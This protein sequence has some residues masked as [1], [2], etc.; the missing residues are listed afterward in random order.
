MTAK[1]YGTF[2]LFVYYLCFIYFIYQPRTG[3]GFFT[4]FSR[5]FSYI[6][7][8][9]LQCRC[10]ARLLSFRFGENDRQTAHL[11]TAIQLWI[12]FFLIAYFYMYFF[13]YRFVR[14]QPRCKIWPHRSRLL[15]SE[16][17]VSVSIWCIDNIG[18]ELDIDL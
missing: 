11:R 6:Y 8:F 10:L 5:R 9:R 13:I 14:S 17:V 18:N 12:A 7:F 3:L 2:L 16:N 4:S 15:V 1:L